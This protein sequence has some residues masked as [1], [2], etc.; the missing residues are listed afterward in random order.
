[1]QLFC[2]SI[3]YRFSQEVLQNVQN[4]SKNGKNSTF[5]PLLAKISTNAG[6]VTKGQ[7]TTGPNSNP[8]NTTHVYDKTN[9]AANKSTTQDT[10]TTEFQKHHHTTGQNTTQVTD[11][12]TV[13]NTTESQDKH[14]TTGYIMNT[15]NTTQAIVT[16]EATEPHNTTGQ[17]KRTTFT[18]QATDTT[19]QQN[20]KRK[21]YKTHKSSHEYNVKEVRIQQKH[22]DSTQ[23]K[24][25]V[26]QQH[27]DVT[28][29][30]G[31]TTV[32]KSNNIKCNTTTCLSP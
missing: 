18:T 10:N 27:Q 30:K 23:N 32:L 21:R 26:T 2:F 17:Q 7:D 29:H 1:M 20:H 16:T 22:A 14:D 31:N 8:Q 5:L 11:T 24:M 19:T 13:K 15:T 12:G 9:V 25:F 6:K 28:L 4:M 3:Y